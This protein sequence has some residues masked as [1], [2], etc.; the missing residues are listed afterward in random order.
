MKL[1]S[2]ERAE[3]AVL[4]WTTRAA[5]GGVMRAQMALAEY[6][7]RAGDQAEFLQRAVPLARIAASKRLSKAQADEC[8]VMRDEQTS[9]LARCAALLM[10][11]G[12]TDRAELEQFLEAAAIGGEKQSCLALGLWYARMDLAGQRLVGAGGLANYKKALRWLSLAAGHGVGEAWFA[13]SR[14]YLKPEFSQRNVA[15]A[16][17]Y[18]RKSADAGYGPAQFELGITAWRGRRNDACKDI[19]AVYWLGKAALQGSAEADELIQK[20]ADKPGKAQW[21]LDIQQELLPDTLNGFPLLKARLD[22]AIEFGLSRAEALLLDIARADCGHCLVIDI[23]AIHP[24]SRRR[25][26]ML[27]TNEQR[28]VL[29]RVVQ[30]FDG[31]EDGASGPEGNY[32]QRLYRL[33][34]LMRALPGASGSD[35]EDD[36]DDDS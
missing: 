3:R 8:E 19:E 23:R 27:E 25:L 16:M 33:R 15:D 34:M 9:L 7:W 5:D 11:K 28:H 10:A 24:R 20:I 12:N 31:I 26:L 13:I 6:A 29:N 1:C 32:R 35:D 18:V 22:L 36:A 4:D 30:L 21:A 17:G 14:I 2:G